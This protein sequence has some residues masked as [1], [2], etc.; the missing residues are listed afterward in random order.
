MWLDFLCQDELNTHHSYWPARL[1][2]TSVVFPGRISSASLCCTDWSSRGFTISTDSPCR[3]TGR[4][5]VNKCT[6][7]DDCATNNCIRQTSF[8]TILD[9]SCRKQSNRA[10]L[11]QVQYYAC[12]YPYG[13][14]ILKKHVSGTSCADFSLPPCLPPLLWDGFVSV[15]IERFKESNDKINT[16]VCQRR[17]EQVFISDGSDYISC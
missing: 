1:R 12:L 2:E 9:V 8:R 16:S 3:P 5:D 6:T 4:R 10:E 11:L 14:Q 15:A 17:I 13:T 7:E